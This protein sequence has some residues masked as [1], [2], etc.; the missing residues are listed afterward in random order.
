MLVVTGTEAVSASNVEVA[1]ALAE[2]IHPPI[3]TPQ[4]HPHPARH[5]FTGEQPLE[6]GMK[7]LGKGSEAW[8]HALKLYRVRQPT[9]SRQH[10]DAASRGPS[11]RSLTQQFRLRC[12]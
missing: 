5:G 12:R 8:M 2:Q 3:R 11:K 4:G 9:G 10:L 1:V 7:T 6:S